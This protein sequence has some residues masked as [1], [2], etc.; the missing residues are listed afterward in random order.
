MW[1]FHLS[2]GSFIHTFL[3][4][5]MLSHLAP[6]QAISQAGEQLEKQIELAAP[7]VQLSMLAAQV[8]RRRDQKWLAVHLRSQ[9]LSGD[10]VRLCLLLL[11]VFPPDEQ[12]GR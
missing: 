12:Y 9:H 7:K 6:D 10:C 4:F 2:T 5:L 3:S 11:H 1:L 8:E